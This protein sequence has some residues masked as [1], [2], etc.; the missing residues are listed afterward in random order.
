MTA[1]A[2]LDASV[3]VSRWSRLLLQELASGGAPSFAPVWSEW[4]IAETW[5]VLAWRACQRGAR[6]PEVS[7]TANLMLRYLL[8]VMHTVRLREF[9]G[10]SAWPQLMDVDDEPLWAAAILGPA[11]YVVS[12]N[13]RHFPPLVDVTGVDGAPEQRHV[14]E[15]VEYLTA[16]EFIEDVLGA[17]ATTILGADL[18]TVLVRSRRRTGGSPTAP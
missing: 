8:P 15:G 10:P 17:D 7:R 9:V 11:A 5:R 18:P 1:R 2:V 12:D 6:W 3:L 14:Y 4:T 13:T 16:I